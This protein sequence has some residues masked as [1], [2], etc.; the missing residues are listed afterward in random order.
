MGIAMSSEEMRTVCCWCSTEIYTYTNLLRVI[1]HQ[2]DVSLIKLEQA[3][4][5]RRVVL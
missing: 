1:E 3:F 2:D 4:F 5:R